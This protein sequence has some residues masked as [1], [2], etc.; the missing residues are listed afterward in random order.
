MK[1]SRRFKSS[2][3]NKL[4]I[5]SLTILVILSGFTTFQ[6]NNLK[7]SINQNLEEQHDLLITKLE[8][9]KLEIF[10]AGVLQKYNLSFE[11]NEGELSKSESMLMFDPFYDNVTYVM[12]TCNLTTIECKT[13]LKNQTL[14]DQF[15]LMPVERLILTTKTK[16]D[17]SE[18]K[19]LI[20]LEEYPNKE[21]RTVPY[22]VELGAD[23][24]VELDTTFFDD[25][26]NYQI[27]QLTFLETLQ[28]A[29]GKDI[30]KTNQVVQLSEDFKIK[31]AE[32]Y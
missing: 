31:M 21:V 14:S 4:I 24:F 25:I 1:T 6:I 2:N 26:F 19:Y 17:F 32:L 11:I 8:H 23:Q 3:S 28:L 12:H 22:I 7:D 13:T 18:E 20:L 5:I 9:R 15:D 27:D 30:N 10:V 29:F 16:E